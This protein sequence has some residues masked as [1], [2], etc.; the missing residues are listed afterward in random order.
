MRRKIRHG[1]KTFGNLIYGGKI[2]ASL[3]PKGNDE[4]V[5]WTFN[6][7]NKFLSLGPDLGF[8]AAEITALVDASRMLRFVILHS[9]AGA[10]FSKATTGYKNA[11]LGGVG[12]NA[13]TPEIPVFTP[14]DTPAVGTVEPGILEFISKALQRAK[15]HANFNDSIAEALMINQGSP[16][17]LNPEDGKPTGSGT[18]MTGSINRIDWT[19]GIF[20][21]V[22]IDSQRGDETVWTRLDFDMR[23][24]YEDRRPPLVAGKPEERRYRLIYFIDNQIVGVWSDVITVI[25]LP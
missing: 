20:D 25:T 4:R 2:M 8:S 3:I 21:G 16:D 6:F 13:A 11:M 23:S 22:Y 7:E 15:L 17:G 10:A 24:P 14:P 1:L 9:Q 5:T 19:K 18:A 12:D